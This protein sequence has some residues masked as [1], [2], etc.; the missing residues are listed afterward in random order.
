MIIFLGDY[1][2]E[3]RYGPYAYSE[4][5]NFLEICELARN[6]H[7]IHLL[8]GNHDYQYTDFTDSRISSY[9]R[10]KDKEF[11]RALIDNIC[12]LHIAYIEDRREK[13]II[14]SHAGVSQTFMERVGISSVHKI[15]MLF[16]ER[17]WKFEFLP[18]FNA[19]RANRYGDNIW[20]SPL[21][22]RPDSLLQDAIPGYE[23]VVGH[24]QVDDIQEKVSANGDKIY[25]TCTFDENCLVL[26]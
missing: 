3:R 22:I 25:F 8:I 10:R 13:P 1:F 19:E 6:N 24:S 16:R 14:F 17:P 15:N 12:L 11:N 9:N 21:W 26:Q 18:C 5:E 20:Q 7:H 2:D 23:Q 4:T